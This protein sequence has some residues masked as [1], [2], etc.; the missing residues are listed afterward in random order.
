[1]H[2]S[3]PVQGV[4]AKAVCYNTDSGQVYPTSTVQTVCI[5]EGKFTAYKLI[6]I[7]VTQDFRIR[8]E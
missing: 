1:V 7:L 2:Q 8:T 5:N 3:E 4:Q 6:S